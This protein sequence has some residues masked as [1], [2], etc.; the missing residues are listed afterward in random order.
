MA[1]AARRAFEKERDQIL[2]DLPPTVKDMF[3]AIG[4]AP[5]DEDDD[6]DD[7]EDNDNNNAAKAAQAQ[8][9]FR[10]VLVVN[11]YNVPPKPVRDV[12]WFDL[13]S[14]AKRKKKL[15]RLAYLVYHYGADD[16]DDCY[17][18][19][20]HDEF[21]PYEAGHAK[22]YDVVPPQL[23][24]KMDQGQPLT[25]QE[26][27]TVRG[28]E[29]LHEDVSKPPMARRRGIAFEER[30]EKLVSSAPPPAKRQ[31]KTK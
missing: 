30:W 3:G 9:A 6:D 13:Y 20:E 26:Q 12:Y 21:I 31:K 10:P 17:S 28:L 23:R 25:E 14:Q 18:F 22:G 16:P 11:P 5:Q 29:E 27:T 7:A 8:P 15:T 19:V 1:D 2:N 24:A 4:F